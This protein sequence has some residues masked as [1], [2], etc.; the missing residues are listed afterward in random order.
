MALKTISPGCEVRASLM[1]FY[2]LSAV[3]AL[4]RDFAGLYTLWGEL[5]QNQLVN[6][7]ALSLPGETPKTTTDQ[8]NLSIM[9]SDNIHISS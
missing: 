4:E 7:S 9:G 5:S 3:F 1:L 2:H 8:R 6:A